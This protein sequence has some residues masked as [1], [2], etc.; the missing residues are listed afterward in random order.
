MYKQK[1]FDIPFS[2]L[3]VGQHEFEFEISKPF[4]DE[5]ELNDV[6]NGALKVDVLLEK[7]STLLVVRFSIEGSIDTFCDRCTDPLTIHIQYED[8]LIYKFGDENFEDNDEVVVLSHADVK[9][10][11]AEP[12]YQFLIIAMPVRKIH[13][14]GD[15]NQKIIDKIEALKSKKDDNIDPRWSAL[16][17]LN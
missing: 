9:I 4:F 10:N 14:E 12:I 16:K 2:G 5:F 1:D 13:K 6:E 3:K 7:Q 11:V 15:C 8:R 17:D